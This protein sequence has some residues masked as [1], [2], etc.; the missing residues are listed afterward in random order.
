MLVCFFSIQVNAKDP[1]GSFAVKG[2][3]T[4]SC[5]QFITDTGSDQAKLTL[6]A[7]YL[8]GYISAYNELKS[9]TFDVLPWQQIDTVMLLLFQQC[10]QNPHLNVAGAISQITQFFDENKLTQ[11]QQPVEI[12]RGDISL[13]FYPQ[14]LE[15]IKTALREKGY[16]SI[17]IWQAMNQFKQDNLLQGKHPFEQLVLMKLLYGK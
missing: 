11:A 15:Q 8:T 16:E 12:K 7:G 14:V 9:Q 17:D 13:L 1:Q 2:V 3:G 4:F 5:E 10:K 6:Y